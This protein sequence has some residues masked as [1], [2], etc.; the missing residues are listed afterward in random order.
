MRY[1]NDRTVG[2]LIEPGVIYEITVD[3]LPTSNVIAR[4][5]RIR[6]DISSSSSPQFDVNPNTG[7]PLGEGHGGIPVR[8]TIFHDSAR[9]SHIRL[10]VVPPVEAGE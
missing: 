10:P 7:G 3:P 1:R 6:L 8:N 2:E 9:P 4:G 5:H